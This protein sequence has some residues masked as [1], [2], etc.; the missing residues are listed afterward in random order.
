MGIPYAR[1]PTG[2][3]RFLP[4]L[5]NTRFTSV[6]NASNYSPACYNSDF[7]GSLGNAPI[8]LTPVASE[9]EDCLTLNVWAPSTTKN[10]DG[11]AA[12]MLWIHGGGFVMGS[13]NSYLWDGRN[14]VSKQEDVIVVSIK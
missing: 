6:F 12:V 5:K 1:P 13:S 7:I 3:L 2:L 10:P 9:S 11:K 14:I 4:P 8:S